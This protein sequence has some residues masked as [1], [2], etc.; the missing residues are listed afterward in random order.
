MNLLQRILPLILLLAAAS[1][2]HAGRYRPG[3]VRTEQTIDRDWTFRYFPSGKEDAAPASP[4]YDD[5]TWQAIALP[6]TW[7]TYETTGDIH[8]YIKFASEREDSYWWNG[9]GWYRKRI[10]IGEELRGKRIF[11]EL[12]G[13]QKYARVYLNGTLLGDHKGGYN[14]FYFD[15]TPHIRFGGENL[16]AVQVSSRRDD[17]FG[18]IPP[19]TAGNFNVYGG[20]Y[21]DVRIVVKNPVYIPFQ[22]SYKHEGGTFVT[23]P[24]V[25]E[26][27]ARFCLRTYVKNDTPQPAEV[28][29]RSVVTDA[30]SKV[31]AVLEQHR[32]L[33][34]GELA[35]FCQWSDTLRTPRLWSPESPY[36]YHIYSEI[37]DAAGR[38][39]DT[40]HTPLGFRWF[41]W[42]Y[43]DNTLSVNGKKIHIHGTNRHQEFPWLGD[44]MP[45]WLTERDMLDIRYG[46]NTNFMRTAHYPHMPA[47][48]D[49][50]D[51]HGIITVEEVPNN[52]AID[53][54]R[55]V[56]EH[57]MREMVRR[58]RNHP[59]I[60]LWSVGN[61]TSNAAD[62]RWTREED[63]TRLI[64]E[65]KAENYGDYVT[66]HASNL[67]MENLLRVTIRGWTDT[68][69]KNLEP[70]NNA[71]VAKSGQ[72]AG[73]EE[74]QHTMARVAD[75]S[76]RGRID[77]QVVGWLYADHGCDRIYKDAPLKNINYKGW[78][79]L[80]RIPKYMYYL[81]Q[82]NYLPEPMVFVHPHYWQRKYL[83]Q[84]RTIR[85]DS[86]C[87]RVELFAGNRSLG[88]RHPSKENFFTVEFPDV[89]IVSET[90]RAVAIRGKERRECRV[91]MA[92]EP[93][94]I[95]LTAL[96]GRIPADRSGL[97]IVTAE[98]VDADGNPVQGFSGPLAWNV[99]GEGTLVGCPL[100]TS[101]IDKTLSDEGTGY[102][103]A[104]VPNVVRSTARPGRI[105]VTVSSPG[106]ASGKITIRTHAVK[107]KTA[108]GI[109]EPRLS[110]EGRT[111]IRRDTAFR[112]VVEYVEEMRPIFAPEQIEAASKEEY[113][114]QMK[115]FVLARNPQIDKKSVEFKCLV[116]KLTVYIENTRGELTED[117]YNFIA[118][119]YN[120]LRMLSRSIEN[121]HFHPAYTEE[122][123][124]YYADRMLVR[125]RTTDI[126][127]TIR[128]IDAI[129]DGL[130]I[131]YVRNPE[132]ST[133]PA[134]LQYGNTTY[135]YSA[136][137]ASVERAVELLHP[138]FTDFAPA[139]RR[140]VM[141][142]L[143]RI[144]P[145][146]VRNGDGYA[147]RFDRPLAIPRN[148]NEL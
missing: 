58:D 83:G 135:R 131:V 144:N 11:V 55:E 82:A 54:D 76:I 122:L 16:L 67:D 19:A 8:P 40:Y 47:V 24:L 29:L 94:A 37:R 33:A 81:W 36:L 71:A 132:R 118:R 86:N 106:L 145:S 89:E 85:V 110:D 138:E 48:Y 116:K 134:P 1:P 143:T 46:M 7:M 64:H 14:G 117:D 109:F 6:H 84:R 45:Q 142:Y 96:R 12:D 111:K 4:D 146:V 62:S 15:L 43:D 92:G 125:G 140:R 95:V 102:V 75:G 25:N 60:F 90:L 69:V 123:K 79:D 107:E 51:R 124:S 93:A 52:K 73:T 91:V 80:Y 70:K 2:C 78:V 35:G 53:F 72:L 137:A 77:G 13:V 108:D 18:T 119:T 126:G 115:E 41:A 121:R 127:K 133:Q 147:F 3:Q 5:A 101:D 105:T 49:F 21:R 88:V 30:D 32:A 22:G 128:L 74:W 61:E 66:H 56:Q 114:R 59:S 136:V 130:D 148:L 104:P 120:D 63:S 44:A 34:A 100:Y 20:I 9:W 68:D 39:L 87:E 65:R 26:R 141:D 31:I 38:L 42:N 57:N 17:R 27:E 98:V 28:N 112:E 10:V 129:P 50:N 99:E 103:T 113:A 97:D 23:T 139:E